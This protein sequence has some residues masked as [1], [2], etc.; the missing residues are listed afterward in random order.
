[1]QEKGKIKSYEE[2]ELSLSQ[3]YAL[4]VSYQGEVVFSIPTAVYW[5]PLFKFNSMQFNFV[6]QTQFN[7]FQIF[8][9]FSV[10][11]C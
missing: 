6:Y 1:M 8:K 2:R 9:K 10:F 5:E 11:V 4:W 7:N 3:S